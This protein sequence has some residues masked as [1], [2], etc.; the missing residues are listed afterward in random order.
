VCVCGAVAFTA[1]IA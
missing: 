1:T